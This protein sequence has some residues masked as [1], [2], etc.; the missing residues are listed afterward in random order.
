MS[1][2]VFLRTTCQ[3]GNCVEQQSVEKWYGVVFQ[4]IFRKSFI[5]DIFLMITNNSLSP[6]NTSFIMMMV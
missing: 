1:K 6:L 2:K 5:L 3:Q 4:K